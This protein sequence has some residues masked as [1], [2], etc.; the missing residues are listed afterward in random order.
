MDLIANIR[1]P[2]ATALAKLLSGEF[3]MDADAALDALHRDRSFNVIHI[4]T[5]YKFDIFPLKDSEY[6][7]TQFARRERGEFSLDGVE[8][9]QADLATAEDTLLMKFL[10]YRMGGEVSDRQWNDIRGIL[11][12]QKDKLDVEYMQR[13]AGD[14][15]V[16]NLLNRA[17]AEADS[18][19]FGRT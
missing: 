6:Y 5:A 7:Q 14:L 17:L 13:W 2:Q 11:A 16:D 4:A 1:P 10:W 3:Y 8:I 18:T 15:K 9:L 12:V 19:G